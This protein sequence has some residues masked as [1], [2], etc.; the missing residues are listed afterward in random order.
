[1]KLR[2]I[3]R[4]IKAKTGT[5]FLSH[6]K[7]DNSPAVFSHKT[8]PICPRS[9]P[10]SSI[11]QNIKININNNTLSSNLS[12]Y[13]HPFLR[14]NNQFSDRFV[15]QSVSTT[16]Y[17]TEQ[18]YKDSGQAGSGLKNPLLG[19]QDSQAG[20]IGRS[21][22]VPDDIK[23]GGGGSTTVWLNYEQIQNNSNLVQN[24]TVTAVFDYTFSEYI[25]ISPFMISGKP[26]E[27]GLFGIQNMDITLQFEQL[28]QAFSCNIV[29]FIADAGANATVEAVFPSGNATDVSCLFTYISPNELMTTPLRNLYPY[30]DIVPYI[31][32]VGINDLNNRKINP[33]V[34]NTL[35]LRVVPEKLWL[36]V[37][38]RK[39]DF[40]V[41]DTN[42]YAYIE[43]VS[44]NFENSQ[45]LVSSAIGEQ[46]YEICVKNGL[47]DSWTAYK[48]HIGSVVC[49]SFGD[50]IELPSS[51]APG[52]QGNF[53]LSVT[54]RCKNIATK[55]AADGGGT[56]D[57][58]QQTYD[59]Y[60]VTQTPGVI[61]IENNQTQIQTG[62]LTRND[63]ITSASAPQTEV[64]QMP[65][66]YAEGSGNPLGG[67]NIVKTATGIVRGLANVADDISP[68]FLGEGC[69]T[70]SAR[71]AGATMAGSLQKGSGGQ[72]LSKQELKKL[73]NR[74]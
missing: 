36:Y 29:D 33:V 13:V 16:A 70:G 7:P 66:S 47:T 43:S 44:V 39:G 20:Y 49:L 56:V 31:S 8:S 38:Q 68:L 10:I 23:I 5:T 21:S 53:N 25:S 35:N 48:D 63:V 18:S 24:D 74:R 67:R 11:I 60:V 1:M 6:S 51:L 32:P 52:V 4:G 34:S 64:E 2:L 12:A 30:S 45:S 59:L 65:D 27:Q 14:Y 19:Y 37:R 58:N 28:V 41:F 26:T 57:W 61:S 15:M 17:D 3:V 69:G 46:L 71:L 40:K 50:D 62:V 42:S 72:L 9:C 22:F 73:A 55:L 54:V